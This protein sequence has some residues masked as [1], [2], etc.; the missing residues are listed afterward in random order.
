M[1]KVTLSFIYAVIGIYLILS[2]LGRGSE[3]NAEKLLYNAVKIYKEISINPDVAPPAMVSSVERALSQII[4]KYPD[5][6][7]AQ[8]AHITLAEFFMV[9]EE[10]EKALL[11]LDE[12]QDLYEQ[13]EVSASRIVFLKGRAFQKQGKWDKALVK[14]T[15]LRDKYTFTQLGFQVPLYIGN[16]YKE[17]GMVTEASKAFVE[18]VEF[19]QKRAG[20][21]VKKVRGYVSSNLLI[22]SYMELGD[23]EKAGKTLESVLAV[24]AS[25]VAFVQQLPKVDRIFVKHLK[26]PSKAIEI[27]RNVQQNTKNSKLAEI[28]GKKIAFLEANEGK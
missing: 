11:A 20:E 5:T 15:E 4:R 6:K 27:Y 19:Y 10:Y 17:R 24:Y 8:I 13:N 1:K 12:M 23:Y 3:Y 16:Y 22:Q 25:E 14:F 18:A 2:F 7:T 28:L 9:I 21:N 26:S